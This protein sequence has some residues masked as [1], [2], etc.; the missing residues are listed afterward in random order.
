MSS[1]MTSPFLTS[2]C[3]NKKH[4]R[5]LDYTAA[6]AVAAPRMLMLKDGEDESDDDD[7]S[8]TSSE[9]KL[10]LDKVY[11]QVIESLEQLNTKKEDYIICKL[12][13]FNKEVI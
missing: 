1:K 4:Q 9:E 11:E 10:I 7:Y 5:S 12:N 3:P 2:I 6:R 13:S 8:T